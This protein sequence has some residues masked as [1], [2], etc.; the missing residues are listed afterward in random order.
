MCAKK[1][2]PNDSFAEK[3]NFSQ[4]VGGTSPIHYLLCHGPE[5]MCVFTVNKSNSV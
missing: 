3:S 5:S 1:N 2:K 4:G